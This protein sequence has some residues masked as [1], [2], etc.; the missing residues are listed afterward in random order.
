[1]E[2]ICKVISF[3]ASKL[4]VDNKFKII[5]L[6]CAIMHFT[7]LI[8][9]LA[10]GFNIMALFNIFSI[11]MY[12]ACTIDCFRGKIGKHSKH[13]INAIFGEIVVH[14]FLCTIFQGFDNGFFV[15]YMLTIPV[16]SYC[17]FFYENGKRF[18]KRI[19][20]YTLIAV[21]F[22]IVSVVFVKNFGSV[23]IMMSI[24]SINDGKL[25]DFETEI[26]RDVNIF[27]AMAALCAFTLMFFVEI[28]SALQKLN[29][30]NSELEYIA[31]HDSLTGLYNRH[32]L[33]SYFDGLSKSGES[34]CVILG[35]IDDFKK[36][37]D[38]YGHDCGD[39]V[40]KNVA[41]IILD[42]V[43]EGDIAVR[44]GGEEMLMILL[45][46]RSECLSRAE[47]VRAR[48]N[49]LKII[50]DGENVKVS[51]TLG[52]VDHSEIEERSESEKVKHSSTNMDSLITIADKRLYDGKNSGK[53]K[54]VA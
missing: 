51:M 53:N 54:V 30:K 22:L 23:Y 47:R 31:E 32:A 48:I 34:F 18:F 38:T 50:H 17:L 8:E 45:G 14:A 35:D 2:V 3:D 1:M 20:I 9:F 49:E 24:G 41:S 29:E 6:S 26:L 46:G 44:W 39:L 7:Y 12:L 15:Y 52:L 5:C 25:S 10:F 40:L 28:F 11:S 16:A 19:I 43:K 4:S 21:V 37:N 33:W 36:V 42:E 13:W 27:Y